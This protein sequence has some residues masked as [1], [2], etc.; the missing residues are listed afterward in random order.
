[1]GFFKKKNTK[2]QIL[3]VYVFR[4]NVMHL[5]ILESQYERTE[6]QFPS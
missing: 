6:M 3:S 2:S 4:K 1:M 5:S